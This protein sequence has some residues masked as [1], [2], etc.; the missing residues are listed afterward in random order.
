MRSPQAEH[1][2]ADFSYGAKRLRR[3]LVGR[4]DMTYE[5]MRLA[6]SR[7]RITVYTAEQAVRQPT[8]QASLAQLTRDQVHNARIADGGAPVTCR[9]P[10]GGMRCVKR[11][12]SDL[13][14]RRIPTT[15]SGPTRRRRG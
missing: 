9:A 10:R 12:L 14:Y 8:A 2:I 13:V 5:V 3:P 1:P 11:R 15:P 4:L 7:L 6:E